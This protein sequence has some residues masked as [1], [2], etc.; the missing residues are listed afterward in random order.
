MSHLSA[1]T[2]LSLS[3]RLA[4]Y[5]GPP[6]TILLISIASPVTGLLTPL[7]FLPAAGLYKAYATSASKD[8]SRRA[9]LEP[10]IWTCVLSTTVGVAAATAVQAFVG[11]STATVLFGNGEARDYFVREA[12]RA[13]TDGLSA[14]DISQRAA[15]AWSWQTTAFNAICS[16]VGA[17]ITEETLKYSP[18][19]YCRRNLKRVDNER[20]IR[21][22]AQVD[23]ALAWGLG[24]GL[25]EA[26]GGIYAAVTDAQAT[27]PSIGLT[28]AERVV[29]G[30]S[31]HLFTAAL[32]ATRSIRKDQ[33]SGYTMSKR[34][35][36]TFFSIIGPSTFLHGATN[37][38]LFSF[39]AWNGNLGW[40]HPTDTTQC[41]G[42]LGMY[43]TALGAAA[44]L[45]RR[46][47][48]RIED[49]EREKN[50]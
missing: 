3:A 18:V 30:V 35:I 21:S 23:Y 47:W 15:L 13:S 40:I 38:G 25:V 22:R 46:E 17:A 33:E 41:I 42:M 2:S 45:T 7:A 20:K 28:V 14:Q 1:N 50:D 48:R 49:G 27:W 12:M 26:V 9:N 37:F 19:A 24:L 43:C 36:A 10:L 8:S 16:F 5:L 29:L 11:Y 34:S 44:W 31:A 39:S 4:L 6:A 32:S